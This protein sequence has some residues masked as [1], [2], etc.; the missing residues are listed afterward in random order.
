[1]FSADR[2]W[3][4]RLAHVSPR[5]RALIVFLAVTWAAP[6]HAYIDPGSGALV[7]Q[8]LVSAFVGV[9]F[10][11]RGFLM[12]VASRIRRLLGGRDTTGSD[13]NEP[14]SRSDADRP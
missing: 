14:V 4:L 6:A 10:F 3:R 7:I 13:P 11:A 5:I 2:G 1:M 8:V 12:R 9:L